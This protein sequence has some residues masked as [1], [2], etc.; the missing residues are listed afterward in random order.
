[1]LPP[2]RWTFAS[3]LE[4]TDT[5]LGH[6]KDIIQKQKDT[7]DENNIRNFVDEY[8]LKIKENTDPSFTEDQCA[9]IIWDIFVVIGQRA[10]YGWAVL[11]LLHYPEIQE[12]IYSEI[13][14]LGEPIEFSHRKKMPYTR[15]FIHESHRFRTAV[16]QTVNYAVTKDVEFRGFTIPKDSQVIGNIWA[17]H[18]EAGY[19]QNPDEFR[20]ERFIDEKGEFVEDSHVITYGFGSRSCFGRRASEIFHFHMLTSLVQRFKVTGHGNLPSLNESDPDLEIDPMPY[21]IVVKERQELKTDQ[22]D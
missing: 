19:W 12:K 4:R 9:H 8:L 21:Q 1:M 13:M 11:L 2:F 6:I 18:H 5:V 10:A 14:A 16:C 7:F 17:V 22:Q 20:P 3:V 15:A